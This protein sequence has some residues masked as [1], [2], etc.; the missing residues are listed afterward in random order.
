MTT[1][2]PRCRP[3]PNASSPRA[4]WSPAIS[5]R[6]ACSPDEATGGAITFSNERLDVVTGDLSVT[7]TQAE[8]GPSNTDELKASPLWDNLPAV[9]DANI[10]ELP[11]PIYN[12]GIHL[13]AELLLGAL[14]DA[15]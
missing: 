7:T 10:I 15:T 13:A 1:T 12:G 11:Q 2:P 9:A 8:G 5:S 14:L 6:S 4:R 3:S